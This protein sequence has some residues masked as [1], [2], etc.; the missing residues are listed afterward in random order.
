MKHGQKSRTL[1]DHSVVDIFYLLAL[2]F[3]LPVQLTPL[4]KDED[5]RFSNSKCL[6]KSLLL[7]IHRINN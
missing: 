1:N 7:E 6:S 4:C 3:V 5:D 2:N